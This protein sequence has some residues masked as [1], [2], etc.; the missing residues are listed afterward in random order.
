M[1][2][3]VET[4][5]GAVVGETPVMPT[6]KGADKAWKTTTDNKNINNRS[7]LTHLYFIFIL[8]PSLSQPARQLALFLVKVGYL[9]AW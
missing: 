6:A 7:E 1:V 2:R 3:T 5:F 8:I 9:P 4:L